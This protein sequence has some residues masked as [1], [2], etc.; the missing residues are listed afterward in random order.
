[1]KNLN[2]FWHSEISKDIFQLNSI[3]SNWLS[4]KHTFINKIPQN[5]IPEAKDD[6]GFV[7]NTNALVEIAN[8]RDDMYGY[9]EELTGLSIFKKAAILIDA[10]RTIY[11]LSYNGKMS[12]EAKKYM[13]V[14]NVRC[15][16]DIGMSYIYKTEIEDDD[17][18]IKVVENIPKFHS[19]HFK[20][21]VLEQ[22]LLH[23]LTVPSISLI[24]ESMTYATNPEIAGCRDKSTCDGKCDSLLIV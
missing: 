4:S 2:Y 14:A 5:L 20:A 24:L 7:I 6:D 19:K 21:E 9:Y 11:P 12:A 8:R 18:V 22:H 16:W 10:I 15:G 17:G 13:L 3:I 1:M 23:K